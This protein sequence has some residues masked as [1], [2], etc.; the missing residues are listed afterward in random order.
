MS[1]SDRGTGMC[2][3]A[4]CGVGVASSVL[5]PNSVRLR[6]CGKVENTPPQSSKN[7]DSNYRVEIESVE[8]ERQGEGHRAVTCLILVGTAPY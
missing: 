3:T 4:Y 1:D 5:H 2:G 6:R 8:L 7:V